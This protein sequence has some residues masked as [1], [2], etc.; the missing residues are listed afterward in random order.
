[1][2]RPIGMPQNPNTSI[3]QGE[4][5]KILMRSSWKR[6]NPINKPCRR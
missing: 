2:A 5:E 3:H 6:R 1:M 4:G